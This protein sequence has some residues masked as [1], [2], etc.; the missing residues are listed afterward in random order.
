MT[1]WNYANSHPHRHVISGLV[2]SNLNLTFKGI[3]L[4]IPPGFWHVHSHQ[5]WPMQWWDLYESQLP[6]SFLSG[7]GNFSASS[8][9]L[10]I[11]LTSPGRAKLIDKWIRNDTKWYKWWLNCCVSAFIQWHSHLNVWGLPPYK[12]NE[13]TDFESQTM[14]VSRNWYESHSIENSVQSSN[15]FSHIANAVDWSRWVHAG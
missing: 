7:Q 6:S 3:L 2:H 5:H 15:L 11:C 12:S 10:K 13:L 4:R 1:K 9:S 8:T 14:S